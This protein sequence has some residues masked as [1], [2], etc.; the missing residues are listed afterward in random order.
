MDDRHIP[1]QVVE[2]LRPLTHQVQTARPFVDFRTLVRFGQV[3]AIIH[4]DGDSGVCHKHVHRHLDAFRL[5]GEGQH[6]AFFRHLP[7]GERNAAARLI[8]H[9]TFDVLRFKQC[10]P[11]YGSSLRMGDEYG[12]TNLVEQGGIGIGIDLEI[13]RANGRCHLTEILV[14][15]LRVTAELHALEVIRPDAYAEAVEPQFFVK[16]R[17]NS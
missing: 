16:G 5:L 1:A 4:H 14:E 6:F 12:G 3:V 8:R 10:L 2:H 7:F 15:R 11:T 9:Y 13:Y 17:R